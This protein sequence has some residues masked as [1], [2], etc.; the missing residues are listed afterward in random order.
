MT[1]IFSGGCIYEFWQN[2]N[3]YGL[4]QMERNAA[5]TKRYA[6]V[7]RVNPVKVAE[8]RQTEW[9]TLLLLED[10]MNYKTRLHETRGFL[11]GTDR[12]SIVYE[13]AVEGRSGTSFGK[14][15]ME[16]TIPESCVDWVGLEGELKF[17]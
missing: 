7:P 11:T 17:S 6:L 9:G 2:A 3:G 5:Q 14:S 1:A 15:T 4:A 13:A 10:F 16:G 8:T 12:S